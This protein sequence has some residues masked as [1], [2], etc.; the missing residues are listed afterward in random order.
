LFTGLIIKESLSSD[1]V[2]HTPGLKIVRSESWDVSGRIAAFQ[3]ATW[4]AIYIE[5]PEEKLDETAGIL[6]QTMLPKWYANLSDSETEHV[7]FRGKIFRHR[8]G[9]KAD[10]AEAIRYGRSLGIPEPQLDWVQG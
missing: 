4:N 10:A 7:I 1:T 6:A 5:G 3:P 9:D 8:K 2:F